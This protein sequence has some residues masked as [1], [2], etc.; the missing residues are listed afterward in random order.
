MGGW[1]DFDHSSPSSATNGNVVP[2]EALKRAENALH[3]IMLADGDPM[4][5]DLQKFALGVLI[6]V[7][8]LPDEY[9][10]R[11]QG[12]DEIMRKL[13]TR[14]TDDLTTEEAYA[15]STDAGVTWTNIKKRT[16]TRLT[17]GVTSK[18]TWSA[19]V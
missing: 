18:T 19:I 8:D 3:N 9:Q 1:V 10:W 2:G 4:D 5:W 16:Y 13:I 6:V 14:D 15:F 11:R 12:T 17:D 7:G